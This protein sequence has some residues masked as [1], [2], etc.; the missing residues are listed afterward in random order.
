MQNAG[1]SNTFL[2]IACHNKNPQA[3]LFYTVCTDS[4][5]Q[6]RRISAPESQVCTL[7]VHLLTVH[8]HRLVLL[9]AIQGFHRIVMQLFQ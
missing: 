6:L 5:H 2:A 3:S 9:L 4:I 7:V 8:A 1:T